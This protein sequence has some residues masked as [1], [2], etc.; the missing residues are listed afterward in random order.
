MTFYCKN[1]PNFLNCCRIFRT[2]KLF[3]S[4]NCMLLCEKID[5]MFQLFGYNDKY[6]RIG[7][8]VS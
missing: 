5:V 3:Q 2:T 1:M 4:L 7:C 6:S 8:R